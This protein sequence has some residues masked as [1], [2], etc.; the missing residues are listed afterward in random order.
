MQVEQFKADRDQWKQLQIQAQIDEWQT[1]LCDELSALKQRLLEEGSE[2]IEAEVAEVLL[3]ERQQQQYLCKE[4][5][6][7][8]KQSLN[9]HMD[10]QR[11][12]MESV[13]M[14]QVSFCGRRISSHD[15][16]CLKFHVFCYAC[17]YSW[18]RPERSK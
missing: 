18:K 5:L 2:R 4:H 8:G 16:I 14:L 6:L 10:A 9:I 12:Q 13:L 1:S 3:A 7:V 11:Q 15:R 17:H